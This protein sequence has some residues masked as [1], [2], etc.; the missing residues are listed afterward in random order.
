MISM[1]IFFAPSV[2][3][4]ETFEITLEGPS[5]DNGFVDV[6]LSAQFRLGGRRVEC[7][8]FYDGQ[9]L[10]KIRFLADREGAWGFST[11][12][13][14]ASLD[15]KSGEFTVTP[16]LPG[17]HGP[18]RVARQF[19]FAHED[20][21]T[22]R[23]VGTTCYAWT[24]QNEAL[25]GKTLKTL[26]TSPF[27]KVRLCVF[28]KHYDYNTNEPPR[29]PFEGSLA[30]G[31]DFRRPN[32]EFFRHLEKRIAELDAM[33]IEADLILFH[34]YDRWGF[35]TMDAATDDFYLR[36]LTAR[37]AAYPNVWWA[38]CNEYDLMQAKTMTDWERFAKIVQENDPWDHLRSIHNCRPFYDHSRAWIT[39]CSIQR[40]DVYKTSEFTDQWREQW[41]KPIVIDECAYEGNINWG[42]GNIT[43]EE[44][45][46]RFW[47]GAV[48][49]GYVGHGETYLNDREE[50]WWSKGGEL[51]GSSPDRI[52][53]LRK[54]LEEGP[55]GGI[56]PIDMGRSYW[57]VPVGGVT[58]EYYLF[59]FGFN[60]ITF[61][62]IDLPE[63]RLFQVDLIDTWNMTVTAL[64]GWRSGKV[65]V[66]LPG[67]Q[68]MAI[69]AVRRLDLNA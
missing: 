63:D 34:P 50:L 30:S 35:S 4:W 57:D 55:E 5:G 27:N 46:R 39:H 37:L 21:T 60:Q 24:H 49:G 36:Y 52:A 64:E 67:R 6:R 29:F 25:E 9:G 58:G 43:G 31:W 65:R 8:G 33:G 54:I 47:E 48:R 41:H 28:P 16:A 7:H 51:V 12:S 20:G 22:Y 3:R 38:L 14:A 59:Y 19:H 15:G 53:F 62:Q 45:T 10:Y 18:V 11:L 42:W 44:M 17:R 69:R 40:Q 1:S 68:F 56:N 13:N 26:Q 61:R 66:D 32:P 2:S 23:P